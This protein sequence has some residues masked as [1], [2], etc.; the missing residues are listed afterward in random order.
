MIKVFKIF[1]ISLLFCVNN[2]F[3]V[4]ELELTQ[5]ISNAIPIAVLPFVGQETMPVDNQIAAI[6]NHDLRNSGRFSLV[7]TVAQTNAPIDFAAWRAQKVEGVVTGQVKVLNNDQFLVSFKLFDVYNKKELFAKEYQIKISQ[8]SK[9]SHHISD[10]IYQQFTGDRG[11]F[12]TKIAYILV[13]EHHGRHARYK[14]Q[15]ADSD[16]YNSRTFLTSNFPLMSPD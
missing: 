4:L 2:A 6:I 16:G 9:L 3:A 5:G 14:F 11:I 15:I 8:S 12:S 1:I 10:I 13:T 7:E